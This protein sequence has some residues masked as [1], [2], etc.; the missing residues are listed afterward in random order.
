VSGGA[1]L[2]AG[3]KGARPQ[4]FA[5]P[6]V[7]RVLS[8][9]LALAGEVAVLRERL[10]SLERL[11]EAGEPVSRAALDA[12]RPDEAAAT[13][14]DRWRE[15]FLEVVLR[16]VHQEREALERRAAETPYEH[17]V[18]MVEQPEDGTTAATPHL[19]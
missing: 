1:K 11:L 15:R 19:N 17:A 8:I 3:P 7:D 14:R 5:D 2:P 13:E 16:A 18:A 12:Y 6:A 4:F 9:T 10:D